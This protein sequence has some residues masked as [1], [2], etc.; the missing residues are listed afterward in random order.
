MDKAMVTPLTFDPF[1][2]TSFNLS[3]YFLTKTEF[4]QY[5]VLA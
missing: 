2:A 4:C 1:D 5:T 3:L